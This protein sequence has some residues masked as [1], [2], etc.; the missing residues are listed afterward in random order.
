VAKSPFSKTLTVGELLQEGERLL[1]ES[2]ES[3]RL[4]SEVLLCF[5][6]GVSRSRLLISLRDPCSEAHQTEFLKVLKRRHA[7]E[8][9]AYILGEREFWG[10]P[11]M[12]NKAVLIPRPESEL[13]VEEALRFLK[14][15]S[16]VKLLD[17]GT[18]S[19]CLA[20]AIAHELRT[21]GVSDL[22]CD[23]VDKSVEA[24]QI[25]KQNVD[26][27]G[28][29][30]HLRCIESNWCSNSEALSPPYDCIV[31]NPPYI[32]PHEKTPV[33]L[34]FEPA[35]A[36]F[37]PAAG[38]FDTEIILRDATALLKPNG[39]LLCEVGAGKRALLEAL[40]KPYEESFVVSL[41]G[42]KSAADRFCVVKLIRRSS[43]LQ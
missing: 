11:F 34:S 23:A 20:V 3:A 22:R 2:S 8:P 10:L 29:S 4:D 32:D 6:I 13:I 24:L 30:Q 36:L 21:Q 18:G 16:S 40:L 38:L 19:G 14:G 28:L 33:E 31:A 17:L 1:A 5:V 27:H 41:V 39:V 35:S 42:D 9:V 25:A 15:R 12:V 7:G 37:S 26:R 43:A